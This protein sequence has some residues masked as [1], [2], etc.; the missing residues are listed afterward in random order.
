MQRTWNTYKTTSTHEGAG[1]GYHRTSNTGKTNSSK[2]LSHNGNCWSIAPGNQYVNGSQLVFSTSTTPSVGSLVHHT[3][4]S[5]LY[6]RP[7]LPVPG[8]CEV[9]T[10]WQDLIYAPPAHQMAYFYGDDSGLFGPLA[11]DQKSLNIR[12]ATGNKVS[13]ANT[14]IGS[15]FNKS[16]NKNTESNVQ[17]QIVSAETSTPNVDIQKRSNKLKW[18]R[19]Y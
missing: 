8:E 14:N 15:Y 6:T 1:R 13:D 4:D 10:K 18:E 9:Q 7:M 12:F 11:E 5:S 2:T 16:E 3:K 17:I 19:L